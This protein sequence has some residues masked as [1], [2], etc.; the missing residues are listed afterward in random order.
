[1]RKDNTFAMVLKGLIHHVASAGAIYNP[2]FKQSLRI[3]RKDF[4]KRT[5]FR[6][7]AADTKDKECE[8]WNIISDNCYP[9]D[10]CTNV[11]PKILSYINRNLHN[12]KYHPLQLI[13]Q[14]IVNYMYSRY[15]GQRGPLFS[16]YDQVRISINS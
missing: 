15:P 4:G 13:K 8:K 6:S 10:S 2:S 3:L 7:F 12:E 9:V 11:T 14:R 16:V 1:M 5:W